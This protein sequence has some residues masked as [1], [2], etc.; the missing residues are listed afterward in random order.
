VPA[1]YTRGGGAQLNQLQAGL[2]VEIRQRL[3]CPVEDLE[4]SAYSE[5]RDCLL[6]S[7]AASAAST[8]AESSNP[9]STKVVSMAAWPLRLFPVHEGVVL[10]QRKVQSCC[11]GG[12]SWVGI[13][14][15]EALPGLGQ[16]GLQQ[17]QIA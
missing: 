11:F 3:H 9:L 2:L 6:A 14:T 8:L 5:S 16:R 15:G 7:T 13:N 12:Q 10:D 17:A 4:R 1:A